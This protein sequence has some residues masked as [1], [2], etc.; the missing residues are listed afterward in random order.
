MA[1]LTMVCLVALCSVSPLAAAS[2]TAQSATDLL[3]Q[4]GD[5]KK[6]AEPLDVNSASL[7]ELKKLP[8]IGGTTAEKIVAGRPF[9]KTSD[10]LDKKILSQ[11]VYEKVKNLI[12]VK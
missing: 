2:V 9:A 4:G 5:L 11:S 3:K 8:G 12:T 6:L 10:L 1:R 7:D